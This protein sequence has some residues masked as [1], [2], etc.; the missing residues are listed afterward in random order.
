VDDPV[1]LDEINALLA[2][3]M[4]A[5]EAEYGPR[6]PAIHALIESELARAEHCPE[7]KRPEG[8]ATEL[9]RFLLETVTAL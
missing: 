4:R 1:L 3:K 5:G 6:R 9:D 8:D 2:L 7:Y